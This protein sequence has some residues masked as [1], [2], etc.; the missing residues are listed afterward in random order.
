[1]A[2]GRLVS[3]SVLGE[4]VKPP[5]LRDLATFKGDDRIPMASKYVR[6]AQ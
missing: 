1:M 3:P 5:V 2:I 4:V 6:G